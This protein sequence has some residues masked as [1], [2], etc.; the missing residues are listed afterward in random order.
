M[1]ERV[2]DCIAEG[3]AEFPHVGCAAGRDET[4]F[5]PDLSAHGGEGVGEGRALLAIPGAG[6][7]GPAGLRRERHCQVDG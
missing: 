2:G 7:C 3:W 6:G 1:A 5:A 4:L